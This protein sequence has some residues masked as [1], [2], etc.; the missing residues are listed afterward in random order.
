M[1]KGEL[2]VIDAWTHVHGR[3]HYTRTAGGA[4][5][6]LEET[7]RRAVEPHA[8]VASDGQV[9]IDIVLAG[10]RNVALCK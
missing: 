3:M 5:L 7:G 10:A 8:G 6:L 4:G 1:E 2:R 9:A